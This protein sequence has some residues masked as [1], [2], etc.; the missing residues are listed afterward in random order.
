M[1]TSAIVRSRVPVW[2]LGCALAVL[3]TTA[4]VEGAA[5]GHVAAT[6]DYVFRGMSQTRG[7]PALQGD[8]HYEWASGWFL[9]AWTSTVDLNP[10]PGPTLE[11]NAYAGRSW[12]VSPAWA[13]RITAV[14]YGYPGDMP[15]LSYDYDE[16]AG[17][18]SFRDR[19]VAS[20]AWSPNTSRYSGYG[21]AHD[22]TALSYDLVGQWPLWAGLS[23]VGGA[24]Y[25]DL[26]DLFGTGY[27]YW[28]LGLTW[29]IRRLQFELGYFSTADRATELFGPETT[30]QRWSLTASWRFPRNH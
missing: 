21:A 20:I 1:P 2:T 5:G 9:G 25:Y 10:G 29:A 16:L 18:L 23:A 30:G 7:A 19:L 15:A 4:R 6:T 22:G 27:G 3:P 26:E 24:G 13:A 12:P 28:S 8:F 17:S 14:H 11:L